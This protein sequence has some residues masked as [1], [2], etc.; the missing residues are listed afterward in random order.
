MRRALPAT[1]AARFP[2]C[3]NLWRGAT[4]YRFFYLLRSLS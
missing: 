1:G 2:P 4:A 3:A